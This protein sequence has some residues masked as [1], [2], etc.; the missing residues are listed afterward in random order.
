MKSN[1][2][3]YLIIVLLISAF[4]GC[5]KEYLDFKPIAKVN[6]ESF[7]L[8]QQDAEQAVTAAYAQFNYLSAWDLDYIELSDIAS[9]DAEAGGAYVNEVPAMETVNR[10]IPLTTNGDVAQSYGGMFRG[11]HFA[12]I[13]IDMLPTIRNK[14]GVQADVIDRMIAEC[15]F[16][17]A[18]NYA[19]LAKFY[20]GVPLVTKILSSDEFIQGQASLF[21]IYNQIE[22]DLK[23]AID[24]L[25][26]KTGYGAGDVGRATKGAAKALLARVLL[27]E[28][29]YAKNYPGDER[30]T[31]LT[32][33]WEESLKYSEEVINSNL[34]SLLGM[35]GTMFK[36]WRSPST[37]GYRYEFTSDADNSVES[38]FEIQ[39][40]PDGLS[41]VYSRGS[42]FA[43]FTAARRYYNKK[44][45][46]NNTNYWGLDLPTH[47]LINE[48]EK[49]NNGNVDPRMHSG[50]AME[51]WPDS[52]EIV[53]SKRFP[54]AYDMSVTKTYLTKYEA[55]S[56]EYQDV[57]KD[58]DCSPL[59]V[60]LIRYSEVLLN[61]T[62]A[63][64]MLGQNDKALQYI[65]MVRTRARNCGDSIKTVPAD[66][67]AGTN[68]TLDMLIHEKRTELYCEGFR[69]FDL[70]RWKLA[71]TILNGNSTAD[72]YPMVYES[73]KH[74]FFPL[75]Q[76]EIE[77]SEGKLKQNPGWD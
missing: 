9:D 63:A 2:S 5:K 55:S 6:T 36:S 43:N 40:I 70:V 69:Y 54:I 56:K 52:I 26:E 1:N 28:S 17:R 30:F 61:A 57:A 72:G 71:K 67:P 66:Y 59:N 47:N 74:D 7:Y 13:A 35:D 48:F 51:G 44:H 50:I 68:I 77:I 15:K 10:L 14:E 8:N 22:K 76:R 62:E 34:Y 64:I 46:A 37:N 23:E 20:G 73:P 60:R 53:G 19:Y 18:I 33:K 27:F 39:C 16:V 31:G 24:V 45:V 58:W 41:F 65:N 11:I 12:N 4:S 32:E 21:D 42:A 75:P 49:D 25:P 29:A 3:K 38:V